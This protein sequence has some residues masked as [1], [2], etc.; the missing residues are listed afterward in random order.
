[1][2]VGFPRSCLLRILLFLLLAFR[3]LLDL[4]R[5][6]GATGWTFLTRDVMKRF[7]FNELTTFPHN[8]ERV[9]GEKNVPLHC[10]FNERKRQD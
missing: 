4:D 10:L 3:I 1:M 9:L 7:S 6:L 5:R 8:G 2:F